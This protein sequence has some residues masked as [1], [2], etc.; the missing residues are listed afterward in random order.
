MRCYNVDMNVNLEKYANLKICAAV[1]GG[2]DSMALLHY[3]HAHAKE[4]NITLTAL[5]CD[6]GIRGETSARDSAFVADYCKKLGV[7]LFSYVADRKLTSEGQARAW[8]F[9]EC[10]IKEAA[11]CDCVATAHHLNDN[12]ETVLFNLARGS[13]LKG[14]EGITDEDYSVLANK[15]FKLI[16]PLI[17]CTRA[18]IDAYI[19]ANEIP[20]VDDETNFKTDYTRNKIRLNILPA[21]EDAVPGA[22]RAIYR[23]SRLAAEDEEYFERQT[24][25]L[26][27]HHEPYGDCIANC[28]EKVI[29]RRAAVNIIAARHDKKD[30]TSNQLE[31]LFNLQFAENGKKFEFLGLTAFKEEGRICIVDNMLLH[32]E[33]EGAPYGHFYSQLADEYCGQIAHICFNYELDGDMNEV[34][35][36]RPETPLK[37]LKFDGGKVPANSVVRFMRPGDKFTKFG[38][39]TKKLGDYF[40]DKKIP[41]RLRGAIPLICDGNEVLIIFGV[42]IS[43]KVKIGEGTKDVLCAIAA[44]YK[45]F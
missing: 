18:E 19:C 38:G 35:Y 45:Q 25:A 31:N 42:E 7:P 44:D 43:E 32:Y 33:N 28:T 21:L 22:A 4:Y 9:F 6:H 16:R 23:F 5:N 27:S 12:A 40:T 24:E 17:A 36:V 30:Y 39:G 34:Q 14:M 10:Y 20:Y 1:S 37:V 8:R 11:N 2:R 3:L 26:I 29:F 13:A 15:P 41:P